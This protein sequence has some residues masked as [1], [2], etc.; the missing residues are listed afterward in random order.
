MKFKPF[1]AS[2]L[3]LPLNNIQVGLSEKL[4][5]IINDGQSEA[6]P[7]TETSDEVVLDCV[8]TLKC[9]YDQLHGGT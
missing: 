4:L 8:K 7:N 9:S 1:L 6:L 2:F 3:S 5:A